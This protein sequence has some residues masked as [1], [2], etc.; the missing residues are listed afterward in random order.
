MHLGTQK[1]ILLL[2]RDCLR[3]PAFTVFKSICELVEFFWA[4]SKLTATHAP[5]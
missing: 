2:A 4:H 1:L 3:H 5:R